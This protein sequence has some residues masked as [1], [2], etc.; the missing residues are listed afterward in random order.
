MGA[1]RRLYGA[2]PG[3]LAALLVAFAFAG[4]AVYA[5][6]Q[7]AE[8]WQ[9]LL[10][11]ALA[12]IVHDFVFLP[13]YTGAYRLAWRLGRVHQDKRRRVPVVHHLVVPTA[14]S[15]L[16]LLAWLPLIL[17]LSEGNYGPTT[18]MTQE[19]YLERWL[20]VTAALF[21]VSGVVYAVRAARVGRAPVADGGDR[22]A[23]EPAEGDR[24]LA[25]RP[26]DDA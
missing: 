22:A 3:H 17:R 24:P 25:T 21:V 23:D 19:P 16:L 15:V 4:Y 5:I 2:G 14:L 10:W 18:G 7:N 8:P 11:L 1:F 9:V 20:A 12:V 13:L 6:F 26:R